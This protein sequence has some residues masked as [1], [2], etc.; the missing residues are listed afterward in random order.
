MWWEKGQVGGKTST[1]QPSGLPVRHAKQRIRRWTDTNR[2]CVIAALR[3]NEDCPALQRREN[4]SDGQKK[5]VQV[6]LL[7]VIRGPKRREARSL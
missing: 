4:K 2:T 6:A 1:P 7:G 3:Q 5:T